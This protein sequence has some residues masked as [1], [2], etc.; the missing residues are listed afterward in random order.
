MKK[1][2]FFD[3]LWSKGKHFLAKDIVNSQTSDGG[4]N[5]V[6]IY[7]KE[8]AI[9]CNW[10]KLLAKE[11]EAKWKSI[12][13][14]IIPGKGN[15]FWEG[16]LSK[17][18]VQAS[19]K[20]ESRIWRDICKAWSDFNFQEPDNIDT[21]LSQPFNFNSFV[22][23]NGKLFYSNL[24]LKGLK[25]LQHI[26]LHDGNF[27]TYEQFKE[28]FDV[29]HDCIL[30]YNSI[31]S[32]IPQNWKVSIRDNYN[33]HRNQPTQ[34]NFQ[35][36]V[37]SLKPSKLIYSSLIEKQS[38]GI[39]DR[40]IVKWNNDLSRAIEKEFFSK[41]FIVAIQ[42]TLSPKL[43]VF[44]YRLLHRNLVTNKDLF[45]WGIKD[46][47]LCTFCNEEEET[48][49]HILWECYFS[50]AVWRQFFDLLHNNT[51]VNIVFSAEEILLGVQNMDN[52]EFYNT[53]FTITKQFLYA[54]KC[55]ET[56]P[57]F[58]QLI[59][60]IDEWVRIEKYIAIKKG[61]LD[62]HNRKWELLSSN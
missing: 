25:T 2:I 37:N 20:K 29:Q 55:K 19:L 3:F 23:I 43:R 39:P 62:K 32:A 52:N 14:K 36:V 59:L 10:I 34:S 33:D 6:N 30:F 61:K 21:I 4:L 60:K 53:L 51:D 40:I 17:S 12:V 11:N 13:N 8:I 57:S 38:T 7:F 58:N 47:N 9:K 45:I 1:K 46:D 44:Q 41:A 31:I 16:N 42:S 48:I 27:I 26:L 28:K 54:C 49:L 56:L 50:Q 15:S 35:K 5:M 18:D 22:R 24:Y